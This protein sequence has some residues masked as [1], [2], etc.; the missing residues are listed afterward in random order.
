MSLLNVQ[1]EFANAIID[2]TNINSVHPAHHIE[3][4]RHN[5]QQTLL[6]LLAE[7]YPLISKLVGNDYFVML[8]KEYTELYPSRTGN[9]HEYGH[10][11]NDFIADHASLKHL[12][13]LSE[14][15]YF[16]WTC[17]NLFFTADAPTLDL[18]TLRQVTEDQY[19]NLHV[20]LNPALALIKFYYPILDIIELCQ[21]NHNKEVNLNKGDTF[22]LMLRSENKIKLQALPQ[23]DFYFLCQLQDGATLG[24][25]LATAQT[26][27]EDFDLARQMVK[28]IKT[29]IIT[30]FYASTG[31]KS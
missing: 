26:Y 25:A 3:I 20:C 24:T 2:K 11:F 9:L 14:V 4:Y 30:S 28:L 12:P 16:E 31:T 1:L 5:V 18:T 21:T 22:L 27:S 8:A 15:A 7:I 29:H 10:Y 6:N 17:H 23:A 19:Q 13:Y